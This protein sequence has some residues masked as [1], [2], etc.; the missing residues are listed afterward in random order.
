MIVRDVSQYS[1]W[2]PW[3]GKVATIKVTG[4]IKSLGQI[5][6][7]NLESEELLGYTKEDLLTLNCRKIMLPMISDHHIDWI[8]SYYERMS[9][10]FINNS[11]STFVKNKNDYYEQCQIIISPIPSLAEIGRAHV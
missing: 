1:D 7:V 8:L 3:G 4:D 5:T 6:N 2:N 9:S 11:I 10:E